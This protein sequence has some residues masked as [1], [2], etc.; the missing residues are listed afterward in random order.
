MSTIDSHVFLP[1]DLVNSYTEAASRSPQ[2]L[3]SLKG[4][5][6]Q[7]YLE[8]FGFFVCLFGEKLSR[9]GPIGELGMEV[10]N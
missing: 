10:K 4:Q 6:I 2:S 9:A 8:K 3:W 5:T 7:S 1:R